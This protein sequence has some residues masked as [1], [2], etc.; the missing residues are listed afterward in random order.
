MF[1]LAIPSVSAAKHLHKEKYYQE[2][3]CA[4]E[5]GQ[6]EVVL[7]DRTRCD[8]LTRIFIVISAPY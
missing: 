6:T 4:K 3:W 8:C 7:P 1:L 2:L 5:K